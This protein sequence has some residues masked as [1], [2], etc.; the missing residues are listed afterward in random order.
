MD[1]SWVKLL[2]QKG[3]HNLA[4]SATFSEHKILC[5]EVKLSTNSETLNQ[6]F[7]DKIISTKGFE[8]HLLI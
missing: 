5:L 7:Q 4:V 3:G 6:W 1:F 2:W 8:K